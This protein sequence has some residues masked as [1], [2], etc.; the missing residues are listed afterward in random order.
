[1]VEQSQKQKS[2]S[3]GIP[4]TFVLEDPSEVPLEEC[5]VAR[6]RFFSFAT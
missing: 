1:M 5:W 2:Y 3:V 6:P 4:K